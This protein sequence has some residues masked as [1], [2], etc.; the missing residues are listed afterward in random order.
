MMINNNAA[1][2]RDTGYVDQLRAMFNQ[3]ENSNA[4]E[5]V[6]EEDYD[7]RGME[8]TVERADLVVAGKE[9]D[10]VLS[11][12]VHERNYLDVLRSGM[13]PRTNDLFVKDFPEQLENQVAEGGQE[14]DE[15]ALVVSLSPINGAYACSL[16]GRHFCKRLPLLREYED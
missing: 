12:I 16:V 14:A 8:E 5:I 4:L 15:A 3:D 10:L 13:K 6:Q 11:P 1:Q 7:P 9:D 2:E